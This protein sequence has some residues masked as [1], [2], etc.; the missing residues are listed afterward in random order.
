MKLKIRSIYFVLA[1]AAS[2]GAITQR[3]Q[4]EACNISNLHGQYSF[5][6]SGTINGQPYAS[7]GQT[8]YHGDGTA[9]GVIQVS[10]GGNVYP[11]ATWTAT[12]TA[13]ATPTDSGATVCVVTKRIT[14]PAYGGLVANFFVTASGDFKQLHFIATDTGST[15]TGT[16]TRE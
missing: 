4:A 16:A 15:I 13:T 9:E 10:I 12:Y 1:L 5:V 14:I 2:S 3:L 7:A 11:V 8:I 6:A